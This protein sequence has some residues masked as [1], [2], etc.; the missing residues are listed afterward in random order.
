MD[1]L[2]EPLPSKNSFRSQQSS[3]RGKFVVFGDEEQIFFEP[4]P[5]PKQEITTI[6]SKESTLQRGSWKVSETRNSEVGG[7]SHR[8]DGPKPHGK[9]RILHPHSRS[10]NDV[11]PMIK[12]L[13]CPF[14]LHFQK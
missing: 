1:P 12:G 9:P 7:K 14:S 11:N 4:N 8:E 13:I 3:A 6:G 5:K 10:L 2:V